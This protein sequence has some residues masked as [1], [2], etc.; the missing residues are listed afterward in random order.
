MDH[1][2]APTAVSQHGGKHWVGAALVQIRVG[3]AATAGL[4]LS[5]ADDRGALHAQMLPG[6]FERLDLT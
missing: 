6:K 5:S 2:W 1:E 4:R 3:F